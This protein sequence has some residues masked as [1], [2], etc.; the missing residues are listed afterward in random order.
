VEVKK[1]PD[2]EEQSGDDDGEGATDE[3]AGAK[4]S[5]D[6]GS[7]DAAKKPIAAADSPPKMIEREF[8]ARGHLLVTVP[9]YVQWDQ[10]KWNQR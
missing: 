6:Q 2:D 9:I 8:R 3:V 1:V 7:A 4:E 5:A 10:N